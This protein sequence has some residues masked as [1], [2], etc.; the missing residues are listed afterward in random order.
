LIIKEFK[1][2]F[3]TLLWWEFHY[4]TRNK[5]LKSLT[6]ILLSLAASKR[7]WSKFELICTK[8]RT[9][10]T[11]KRIFKLIYVAWNSQALLN[12]QFSILDAEITLETLQSAY[13]LEEVKEDEEETEEE[14]E[15]EIK[16]EIEKEI[17]FS[18]S[19]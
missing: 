12:K 10:L 5:Y 19:K 17:N 14:V 2:L 3:N 1:K 6:K 15:E 18:F 11:V 7:A 9:K 16:E 4:L 8:L 13:K